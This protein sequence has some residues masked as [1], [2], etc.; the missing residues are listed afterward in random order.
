MFDI[1]E[2]V[3]AGEFLAGVWCNLGSGI[4]AEIASSTG[5]DW[6]LIDQEHG[7]GDNETLL[8]QLQAMG[9]R[10]CAPIVRIA[11]NEAPRFKRALDLGAA[12]IMVPYVQTVEE[13]RL[14]VSSLRYPPE[15]QR[16]V[17]V[18]PRATGFGMRFD[19]Y[20]A[21]ANRKLLSV[22]QIETARGVES[23]RE[24][25]LV[26]GVDVLFVG[27]MDLSL[28]VGMP[29]RFEDPEFRRLLKAI[30]RGAREVG[31]AAGILIPSTKLIEMV[32]DIGFTFVAVGSDGGMV[33]EGMQK[34][35][36]ALRQYKRK[37]S[38]TS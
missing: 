14:A 23:A 36:A 10:P 18:S 29:K 15:G 2:K 31:K 30:A 12:G 9:G 11:W 35:F 22:H 25:A 7:P 1:R 16:G 4:T 38:I 26:D 28:S 32:H 3:F 13:A 24:I 17:A 33:V 20:F 19:S 8:R 37:T 27:P 34:N 21:E 6:L 5:F